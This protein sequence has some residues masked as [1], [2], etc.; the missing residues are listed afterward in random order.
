MDGRQGGDDRLGRGSAFL[1]AGQYCAVRLRE[2]GA[3]PVYLTFDIDALD[4]A[5]APGRARPKSTAS[6]R[7]KRRP[8]FAD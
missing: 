5:F 3:G 7:G 4:P 1:D 6:P 8:F 2:V